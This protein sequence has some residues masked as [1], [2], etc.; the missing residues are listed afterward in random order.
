MD[1]VTR[2]FL[3]RQIENLNGISGGEYRLGWWTHGGGVRIETSDGRIISP[4]GTKR[5]Q[6]AVIDAMVD[7][8]QEHKRRLAFFL[9]PIRK[10]RT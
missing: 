9:E 10:E 3:E 5:Q 6:S 8:I 4:I 2:K 1:A 7:A